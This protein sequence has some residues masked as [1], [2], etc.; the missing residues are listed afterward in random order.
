MGEK[1][2]KS[3]VTSQ[4]QNELRILHLEDNPLDGELIRETLAAQGILAKIV[5]VDTETEFRAA[6]MSDKVDLVL[7][8][9][10]L[11]GFGG[12]GALEFVRK[13]SPDLPFIFVSGTIG[14][15]TAIESLKNGATDYVL[16]HRL[17]RLALSVRRAL[18]EVEERQRSARADEAL[19]ESEERYR[20]LFENSPS[21]MWVYDLETLEFLVVNDA[22]VKHYGYSREEFLGMTIKDIRPDDEVPRLLRYVDIVSESVSKNGVW[23]HLTKR[24]A[25]IEVEITSY[26]ISFLGRRAE[27]VVAHDVTER[28]RAEETL[29]LQGAA[30]EAAANA[31]VITDAMGRIIWVNHAF[32]ESSGFKTEEAIGKTPRL[33]KS[34]KQPPEFYKVMWKTILAGEVWHNTITNRCKDG[35]QIEEDLTITPILDEEQKITHFIGIKQDITEL[36]NTEQALKDTNER[37]QDAVFSLQDKSDE[38]AAMTQQLWQASKLATM[39]ELSASIAHELNNPLATVSLR[40]ESLLDQLD[41][42]DPKRRALEVISQEVDRMANLVG[43]LL[44]FSRRSHRQIS[45]IDVSE[46]LS[47]SLDL[48]HY[49]LQSHRIEIVKDFAP[50]LPTIQADRQQLRQVFLNL[51][52]NAGDAMPNGGAITVRALPAT[53]EDK[54]ALLIELSDTGT[55]I[56]E[57]DL[58]KLWEPFFTT[59]S[60]GKGTG[61]GLPICRRT[62]EEHKGTISISSYRGEGTTV[63]VLLPATELEKAEQEPDA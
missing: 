36:K 42:N 52:T 58:P 55:G 48:I 6:L 40:T 33:L 16:K 45:T 60:E 12:L 13:I 4:S 21:P 3:P 27:V 8:D 41:E 49:H 47:S 22:A 38:L 19:R 7:S 39:G 25:A 24:G 30:L 2:S 1:R 23:T 5:S 51:L 50:G 34:G 43:N 10:S 29:R 63:S 14:E 11:P 46:E 17:E 62:I 35:S 59:K 9:Y 56:D 28:K 15:D 57:A 31:I 32:T 61:L 26:R 44:T 53:L 54:N 37:L 18:R 20:V